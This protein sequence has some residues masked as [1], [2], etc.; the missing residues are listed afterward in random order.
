M[1]KGGCRGLLDNVS[2]VI[3]AAAAQL[4]RTHHLSHPQVAH[5]PQGHS[6]KLAQ[7]PL[8]IVPLEVITAFQND[9]PAWSA[10]L[11]STVPWAQPV[12]LTAQE[13]TTAP[14]GKCIFD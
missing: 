4:F 12:T 3:I 14:M 2:Q 10:H 6:A 1:I 5:V 8:Q 7:R 13:V 9:P 11:V